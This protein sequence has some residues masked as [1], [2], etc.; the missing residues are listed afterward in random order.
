MSEPIDAVIEGGCLCGAVR[1]R[2][3][4]E[5]KYRVMC[6][7]ES[8]RRAAGSPV[9]AWVTFEPANFAFTKGQ[10]VSYRSSPPVTRTFC[11][12]CGTPLTYVRVDR[13]DDVDLTTASLDRPGDFP[14]VAHLWME[15]ALPW[16]R[17]GDELPVFQR[18]PSAE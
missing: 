12:T 15:D 16:V 9:V 18:S 14:P 10:P 8:C 7:C 3:T 4:G 13:P 6:H 17:F 5:P 11:G 1:Y 2:V